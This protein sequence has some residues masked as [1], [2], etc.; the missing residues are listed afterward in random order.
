MLSII[1]AIL[2]LIGSLLPEIIKFLNRKEDHRH[3]IE[4]AKI[5]LEMAEKQHAY[6][7]AEIEATAD[8]EESKAL[9]QY[10][11]PKLTGVKWIDAITMLYQSSVRPTVTYAFVAFFALVKYAK[12]KVFLASGMSQWSIIVNLWESEDMALFSTIIAFW[13][14]QRFLKYSFNRMLK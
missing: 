9:Y 8:I 3:E 13:F 7:M 5:Q 12:Y 6:R 11:E 10:A 2:G 4:M 1:G 14:G